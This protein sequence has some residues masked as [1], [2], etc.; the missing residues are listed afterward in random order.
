MTR[1][2][3][4]KQTNKQTNQDSPGFILVLFS[5]NLILTLYTVPPCVEW[6]L[7]VFWAVVLVDIKKEMLFC[8]SSIFP[9][10]QGV[11]QLNLVR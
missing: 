4:E 7:T 1:L 3:C 8:H 11:T 6:Y 10:C 2:S 5:H 9:Q